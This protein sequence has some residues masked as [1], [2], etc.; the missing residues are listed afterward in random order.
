MSS[1]SAAEVQL[2]DFNGKPHSPLRADTRKATVV[3]FTLPDCP[4]ANAFAP[5]INRLVAEY[6][7]RGVSFYLAHVDRDLTAAEARKHAADFAFRCP[8]LLDSQHALVKALGATKTPQAYLLGPDGKT[9]YRGRI[10]NLFADYGQ[11]RQTVTQHD[12]R[13]ALDAVLAG[14]PISQP[15]TEAIGCHIQTI[16]ENKTP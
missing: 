16:S 11:R 5:E 15:I 3:I 6:S 4:V 1:S 9:L 10:N 7:V 8:V 13:N 14:K 2:S 12:L